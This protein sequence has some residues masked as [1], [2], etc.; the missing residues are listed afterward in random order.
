MTAAPSTRSSAA[1]PA[2][3][4]A[5]LA[6]ER[7]VMVEIDPAWRDAVADALPDGVLPMH[8]RDD[9][10]ARARALFLAHPIP[11]IACAPKGPLPDGAIQIGVSFPF[12]DDGVRVRSA[13][14]LPLAAVARRYTPW[15][16]AGAI[17][18][19]AFPAADELL[20][21]VDLGR[22]H[23]VAVGFFGSA[24][25]HA[26]TGL[27]YLEAR[28]DVDAVVRARSVAGLRAFYGALAALGRE[29]GRSYD[30]EVAT[31]AGLGVKLSELVTDVAT[32]LGRG[33]DGVRL[34]DRRQVLA[35]IDASSPVI[36]TA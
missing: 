21:L 28:S 8:R 19:G 11:G 35:E 12:R 34:V 18:P 22:A 1:M 13:V 16:I 25:L 24:A 33:L 6:P 30:I 29:T 2:A 14:A 31:P 5:A 27:A 3:P 7:H 15:D 10:L 4:A 17:T 32:V 9:V 23:A 26:L 20:A 36:P